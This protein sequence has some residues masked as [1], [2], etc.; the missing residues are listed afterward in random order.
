MGGVAA[1][2]GGEAGTGDTISPTGVNGGTTGG[3]WHTRGVS[4]AYRSFGE[5]WRWSGQFFQC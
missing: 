2:G 5:P 4:G 3:P 1:G